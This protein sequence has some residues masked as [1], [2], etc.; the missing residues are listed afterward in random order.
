LVPGRN[1]RK[2]IWFGEKHE[3]FVLLMKQ[4]DVCR[5]FPYRA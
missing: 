3:G 1:L 5:I 2:D 4:I